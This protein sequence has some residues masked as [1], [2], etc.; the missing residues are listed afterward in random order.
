MSQTNGDDRRLTIGELARA[1]ERGS[2]RSVRHGAAYEVSWREVNRLQMRL[3]HADMWLLFQ[4]GGGVEIGPGGED[5]S[6]AV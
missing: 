1:I 5:V 4:P 3:A 6:Q 2:I